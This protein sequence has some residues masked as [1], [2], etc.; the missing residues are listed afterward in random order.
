MGRRSERADYASEAVVLWRPEQGEKLPEAAEGELERL[1][2]SANGAPERVL[3]PWKPYPGTGPA[4]DWAWM[5]LVAHP[6][7]SA[8]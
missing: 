4:R 3:V 6:A 8:Q 7:V 5:L 1:K 2:A